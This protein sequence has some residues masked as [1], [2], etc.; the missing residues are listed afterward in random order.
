MA[1]SLEL[2]RASPSLT[3]VCLDGRGAKPGGATGAGQGYLWLSHRPV[4]TPAWRLAQRG[5]ELW[6]HWLGGEGS[7]IGWRA[8]GSLLLATSEA[9]R[10][11]LAHRALSLQ[12]HGVAART[13]SP[14]ALQS[15]EPGLLARE[16]PA[17]DPAALYVPA[18]AQISGQAAATTLRA[19][20]E[21]AGA[22]R[23]RI[24]ETTAERLL[25]GD[26][27]APAVALADASVL[28]AGRGVVLAAGAWSSQLLGPAWRGALEPRR[29]LM[30]ELPWPE[31]SAPLRHGCMEL[32]YAAHY[33]PGGTASATPE[34]LITFTATTSARGTLF[35]GSSR[36]FCGFDCGTD[37]DRIADAIL[38]RARAFLPRLPAGSWAEAAHR[39]DHALHLGLR[40]WSRVRALYRDVRAMQARCSSILPFSAD[41]IPSRPHPQRGQPHIGPV[42]GHPG[43]FLAAGHEGSGLLLAPATAELAADHVL[44]RA[45]RDEALA[46]AFLPGV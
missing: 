29:G 41:A 45:P 9:E 21:A 36:E 18:D 4:G 38:R 28:A 23:F 13:L 34:S 10:G 31:G 11:E 7:D 12:E 37:R 39:P 2:L 43:V 22:G 25:E 30:L 5:R 14:A 20:C 44:E 1:T 19:A 24:L 26:G 3:V 42:P 16:G 27:A 17:D 40:P 35:L 46:H 6:P 15:L 8:A 32:G 33:A